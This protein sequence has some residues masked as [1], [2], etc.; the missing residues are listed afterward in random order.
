M[1]NPSTLLASLNGK[2]DL[3]RCEKCTEQGSSYLGIQRSTGR[4][5]LIKLASSPEDGLALKNEFDLL[6]QLEGIH[7]PAAVLFPRAVEYHE[8]PEGFALIRE[9]IPGQSLEAYVESEPTCPGIDR[10]TAVRW[11]VS[12]LEQ[13][14]LLH[15]LRPPLIHRDIKPQNVVVDRWENCHLIDLGIARAWREGDAGDT[16]VMGTGLTAPPEQF[17]YKQTD[18]R[19]DIYSAGVLLRYCLT[20]RYDEGADADIDADLRRVVRK[21]TQFDPKNRYRSAEDMRRALK[22]GRASRWRGKPALLALFALAVAFVCLIGM[23]LRPAGFTLDA[24]MFAE[25]P[26]I[27]ACYTDHGIYP[28]D[29]CAYLNPDGLYLTVF[30]SERRWSD[31]TWRREKLS[32]G[33][34]KAM[35][36]ALRASGIPVREIM[37]QNYRF[38]TLKPLAQPWSGPVSLIFDSCT[39]PEDWS[40]LG[41][42]GDTLESLHVGGEYDMSDLSWLPSLTRL[43][44]LALE[45]EDVDLESVSR[46]T[47][48]TGL[49]IGNAQIRD[50][51]PLVRLKNLALLGLYGNHLRDLSPLA[52]MPQLENLSIMGNL[53]EDLS[54]LAGLEN[55]QEVEVTDNFITDFSPIE[56]DGIKIIGR[57]RQQGPAS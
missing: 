46:T 39:L 4:Q 17:G 1:N 56:R 43:Q 57:D 50:L 40:A 5:V 20:E 45:G 31:I 35:L 44:W 37:L 23:R 32:D 7:S 33:E 15:N 53:V 54:P 34:L 9:Y 8:L 2:Y 10:D 6:K 27:Y 25:V 30:G 22:T 38:E 49:I 29:V 42:M 36:Q 26:E 47:S 28:Y 11:V 51:S 13:L 14:A 3:I 16:R 21:A 19:S 52:D 55:L 12:V 18:P 48:L 41:G 24:G